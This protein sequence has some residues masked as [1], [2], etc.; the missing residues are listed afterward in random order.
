V[1][2]AE[3]EDPG[4]PDL[5]VPLLIRA[6]WYCGSAERPSSAGCEPPR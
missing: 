1:R 5:L 2:L 4:W 3:G 6:P